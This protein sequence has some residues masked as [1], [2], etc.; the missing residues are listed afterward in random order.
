MPGSEIKVMGEDIG[1]KWHLTAPWGIYSNDNGNN[2][3]EEKY[4]WEEEL[5]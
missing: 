5:H 4:I 1:R 2:S 3:V